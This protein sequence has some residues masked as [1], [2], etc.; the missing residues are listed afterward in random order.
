MVIADVGGHACVVNTQAWQSLGMPPDTPGVEKN[1][2]TGEPTGLLVGR[3]NTLARFH[4]YSQIE[5][6]TRVTALH[7]A[8]E[9]AAQVGITTVH[10]LDGGS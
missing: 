1:P 6:A 4:F 9:I 10:T 7:R 3:A 5:D 2:D 8:A